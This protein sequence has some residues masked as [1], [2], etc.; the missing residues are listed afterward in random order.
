MSTKEIVACL[1]TIFLSISAN[2][3]VDL[4]LGV[5]RL[6]QLN[7]TS[8]MTPSHSDDATSHS[9]SSS[10]TSTAEVSILRKRSSADNYDFAADDEPITTTHTESPD[11]KYRRT[12]GDFKQCQVCDEI[13]M[14]RSFFCGQCRSEF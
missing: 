3:S 10:S 5:S 1:S 11:A 13:N 6:G 7:E 12:N 4:P 14:Q 9:S 2:D 8:S